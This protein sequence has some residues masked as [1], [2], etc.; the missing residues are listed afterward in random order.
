MDI[1]KAF[2]LSCEE[3]ADGLLFHFSDGT[4]KFYRNV[5]YLVDRGIPAAEPEQDERKWA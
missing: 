2:P 5:R 4:S 1:K 3:L